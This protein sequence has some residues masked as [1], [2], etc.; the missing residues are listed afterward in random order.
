MQSIV[1]HAAMAESL[2]YTVK[3]LDRNSQDLFTPVTKY[4]V[5]VVET[6]RDVSHQ[7]LKAWDR[8]AER[9]AKENPF[10]AKVLESQKAWASASCPYRRCCHPPYEF[11]ADYYWKGANPY[12][13]L[14]P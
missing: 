11:A 14:K 2:H 13:I 8:V 12:K 3:M 4:G 1:K 9:K 7:I 5:T 6:P 10:F